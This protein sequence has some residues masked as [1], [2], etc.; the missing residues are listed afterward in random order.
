[1]KVNPTSSIHQFKKSSIRILVSSMVTLASPIFADTALAETP[2]RSAEVKK[3]YKIKSGALDHALTTFASQSGVVLAFDPALTQRKQTS[4]LDGSYSLQQGFDALLHG[5][6][7]AVVPG[8]GNVYRLIKMARK[9]V[10]F[11][12]TLPEVVVTEA[13][14]TPSENDS[15]KYLQKKAS[16]TSRIPLTIKESPMTVTVVSKK[17]MDEFAVRDLSDAVKGVAS[18]TMDNKNGGRQ[19]ALRSR[20]F[21]LDDTSAFMVDGQPLHALLDQPMELMERVEV[22]RGPS[23]VQYGRGRGSGIINLIRKRPTEENFV[24][25]KASGGS[26]DYKQ[27]QL[28]AGG[29]VA[30]NEN[31]GYRINISKEDSNTF[32]DDVYLQ[33]DVVGLVLDAK[34]TDDLKLTLLADYVNRDTPWDL[35]QQWIN[36]KPAPG[37]SRRTYDFLP[38]TKMNTSNSTL[39][40]EVDWK[41]NDNWKVKHLYT[42]QDYN[43]DRHISGR[44]GFNALTGNFTPTESRGVTD[45]KNHSFILDLLGDNTLLGMRHRTVLGYHHVDLSLE[46]RSSNNIT[47]TGVTNNIYNPISVPRRPLTMSAF[48]STTDSVFKGLYAEDY[49]GVLP[50]L[51]LMLG[52]RYDKFEERTA[53]AAAVPVRDAR[54]NDK[55]TP[56]V[57]LVYT[58]IDE[59]TLYGSYMRGFEPGARAALTVATGIPALNAGELFDP[60][61][62]EQY[63]VGIKTNLLE[64]KLALNFALYD[65]T[66]SNQV[67][68]DL[69]A[70][71]FTLIGEQR[72]KGFE[73]ELIGQV[74]PE[75]SISASYAYLDS[76][77]VEGAANIKGKNL[78]LAP[79]HSTRLWTSYTFNHGM[80]KNLSLYGGMFQQSDSYGDAANTFTVEGY[81]RFDAGASYAHQLGSNKAIWR[82]NVDN[83]TDKVYYMGN[84]QASM[85]PGTPRNARLSLEV[86]F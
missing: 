61:E 5:Y 67:F 86:L 27:L 77:T 52:V 78:N 7:L 31:L 71:R 3:V 15:T 56:R 35:G 54:K 60:Q 75:W 73:T 18:V 44:S 42:F 43:T 14:N 38:W 9:D 16:S 46:T 51:N 81:T 11:D 49:I 41:L 10:E 37:L 24:S 39:G 47:Y 82:L 64:D 53:T 20:G 26:W 70:R 13:V 29:R 34:I 55:V 65:L 4:G 23:G 17:L 40:Y 72:T 66:R 63:E 62:S 25:I 58:P 68:T 6:D 74:T 30:D 36:G 48:E 33:K 1:M 8:E 84:N 59:I 85:L 22:L 50:D 32:R 79:R 45:G 83:I 21:L 80:L 28:D 19:P 2:V 57:G 12:G 69:V 76:E